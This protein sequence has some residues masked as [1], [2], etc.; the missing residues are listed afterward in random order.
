MMLQDIRVDYIDK[1]EHDT[2]PSSVSSS[3]SFQYPPI[4][5]PAQAPSFSDLEY[6]DN[7]FTSTSTP[8]DWL[9]PA[10]T[11]DSLILSTLQSCRKPEDPKIIHIGCG[12]SELS[13]RLGELVSRPQG[14]WNTD[15]SGVV[16]DQGR[17][18]EEE[19]WRAFVADTTVSQSEAS[20]NGSTERMNWKVLDLL[21]PASVAEL[22]S[23]PFDLIIDKS[24]S[25]AIS[26]GP[27]LPF[28]H[29]PSTA[30]PGHLLPL[31]HDGS[32][33]DLVH[34][35]DILAVHLARLTLPGSKWL[36]ISYSADRFEFLHPSK[37]NS[38]VVDLSI[39]STT[40]DD[41][42]S[43]SQRYPR[44]AE[45]WTLEN[46]MDIE[47][48]PPVPSPTPNQTQSS[49]QSPDNPNPRKKRS[50]KKAE[51]PVFRPKEVVWVY[52]LRRSEVKVF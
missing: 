29:K 52:V 3:G 48:P 14:V 6:W 24:T 21:D 35:L 25:D 7:R 36:S 22:E 41:L 13:F 19:R 30:K 9:L 40:P 45:L 18:M 23:I 31:D 16:I 34:P 49:T 32:Q 42:D 43:N 33:K 12:S 5:P 17:A 10:T 8:F 50:V 47:I 4:M 20:G 2:T 27:D 46:K 26:C 51:E 15:Y 11:L 38:A 37:S 39:N 28:P 44:P 1:L